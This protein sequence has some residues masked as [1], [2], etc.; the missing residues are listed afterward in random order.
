MFRARPATEVNVVLQE[1][2]SAFDRCL[3][4]LRTAG[5]EPVRRPRPDAAGSAKAVDL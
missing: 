3:E 2:A 5:T 4:A 1:A